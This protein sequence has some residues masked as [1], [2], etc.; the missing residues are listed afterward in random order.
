MKIS[1]LIHSLTERG[2][3]FLVAKLFFIFLFGL[4]AG[5]SHTAYASLPASFGITEVDSL[6]QILARSQNPQDKIKTLETLGKRY[7]YESELDKALEAENQ[8]LEVIS[9]HGTKFD[10]A[11][12]FRLIGLVY[13]QKSWYDKSLDNFMRAQQLFGEYGD[14]SLQATTLMNVG[15]VHDY[16]QNLPMSLAYYNKALSFFKRN[17]DVTGIADCELNIAILLIKQNKYQQ[18]CENLLSAAE[19]YEKTGNK[20]SLAAAYINLGLSYKKMKNFGLA[21]DYHD[22]ALA[23]WKQQDDQYHICMYYLNMGEIMLDMQ[24]PDD[25][26]SYLIEAEALAKT[27]DS[28][29][30]LSK[31]YEFLSD[32]HA[33]RKNFGA[34]YTYLN[35]SKQINDSILNAETTE[36]VNQI[37]YQYE[38]SKREADN[39]H[40]VKQNLDKELQLSKKN[41]TLYILT[42]VLV[43]IALLVLLL[44]NQNR[45]KRRAN[46]KLEDQNKQI[47]SQKDE[48]VKLNASK[49]RFLSILA[50]DIKNPLSSIIGISEILV[51]DYQTLSEKERKDF[52]QDLHM[53]AT[54]LSEIINTLLTWSTSQSGLIT[55]RPK[56]FSIG[57]LASKTIHNLETVAKQKD[58]KLV[59][60]ADRE[61]SVLAD[62][63]MIYSVFHNLINNAIKFSHTGAEIRIETNRVNGFAEIS[64]IDSGIG[65]SPESQSKLF[66]YDQHLLN[67]GT[68]GESGT[69]LGLILCKDFVE[70]NG[71][72]IKV[73]SAIN[74]GSTFVFT[75]PIA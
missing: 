1:L 45:L 64:V 52:T 2:F 15:I 16:M 5:F 67:K 10:S 55:Y 31:A 63:N 32:Y 46:Q 49:D 12:C 22:K 26:R 60:N 11:K 70:K 27:L 44:V 71:G 19:I 59:N 73:E 3:K 35:K 54:N 66:R 43:V 56:T 38:I 37:Q 65:L 29:D 53:L 23:I 28:K 61:L 62:E 36:K 7:Y 24:K 57:I 25:A 74:K 13:L 51:N 47:E 20:S 58:L 34:A 69:G 9:K 6:K 4:Y 18:A 41:L 68:A 42:G 40:L 72:T 17:N 8:L 75:L 30:L 48:L 21:I 50:H 39:E 33:A 14:S